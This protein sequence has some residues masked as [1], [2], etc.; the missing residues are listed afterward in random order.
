[1]GYAPGFALFMQIKKGIPVSP[2]VAIY[3]AVVLNAEDQPIPHRT[4]PAARVPRELGRF[5]DALEA[6]R[7]EIQQL[8]DQT[9]EALGEELANIFHFHLGMLSDRHLIE[10]VRSSIDTDHVT[11]EFAVYQVLRRLAQTFVQQD[12]KYLR[13]RV[14]DV[15][16]LER[17]I[18]KHL[19]G[20]AHS[21]LQQLDSPAVI[22]AHDLT[23]SRPSPTPKS[24]PPVILA[25]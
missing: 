21:E 12:R 1:M 4:V 14:S 7:A 11:A 22:L 20:Y 24:S 16:D 9:A 15:W 17:R 10:Q 6:S 8:R 19:V 25:A 3:P 2:G 18:L 13:E 23:P 5:E